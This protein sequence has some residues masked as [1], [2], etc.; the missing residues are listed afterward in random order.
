MPE[1]KI[2]RTWQEIAALAAN[3]RDSKK[4]HRL[5]EELDRALEERDRLAN[6]AGDSKAGAA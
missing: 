3:E 4:L 5:I 1:Q 2:A 6:N